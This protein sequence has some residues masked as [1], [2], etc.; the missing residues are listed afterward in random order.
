MNRLS[1]QW[2]HFF[3][4]NLFTDLAKVIITLNPLNIYEFKAQLCQIYK[5]SCL[6][7]I[8]FMR[9]FR[10]KQELSEFCYLL[11]GFFLD[12]RSLGHLNHRLCWSLRH[13][14]F[15]HCHFAPGENMRG[16]N[17]L[18]GKSSVNTQFRFVHFF[19]REQ[20]VRSLRWHNY[21]TET[22]QL[23]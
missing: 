21:G 20:R 19:K 14:W 4:T 22:I 16:P 1:F 7:Y 6:T 18:S 23:V 8:V 13:W 10:W 5:H 17:L 12:F 15:S 2:P 9:Q 11:C 3:F